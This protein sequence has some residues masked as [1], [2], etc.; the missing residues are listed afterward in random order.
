M[1]GAAEL[2]QAAR[3]MWGVLRYE[4]QSGCSTKGSEASYYEA[5]QVW[6]DFEKE[7]GGAASAAAWDVELKRL[8]AEFPHESFF[9]WWELRR[10][11]TR[12][13][14]EEAEWQ[15]LEVER[16]LDGIPDPE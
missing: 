16:A 8:K 14:Q 10:I 7:Q 12:N 11:E 9:R 3:K 2:R 15:Q 13:A 1:T 4:Y 5:A 6:V